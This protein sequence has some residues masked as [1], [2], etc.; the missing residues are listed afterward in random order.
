MLGAPRSI[1]KGRCK[2]GS[3]GA[4]CSRH[5]RQGHRRCCPVPPPCSQHVPAS[6]SRGGGSLCPS[7]PI[8]SHRVSPRVMGRSEPLQ[9]GGGGG[10]FAPPPALQ[11]GCT[12]VLN[13]AA[14]P[15][16]KTSRHT[17][18]LLRCR[19]SPARGSARSHQRSPCPARRSS[20]QL[21][22]R[23][24]ATLGG[25]PWSLKTCFSPSFNQ[26]HPGP[27]PAAVPTSSLRTATTRASAVGFLPGPPRGRREQ[28]LCSIAAR[29]CEPPGNAFGSGRDNAVG[30]H[31]DTGICQ[32]PVSADAG[33]FAGASGAESAQDRWRRELFIHTEAVW[34]PPI[35]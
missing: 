3:A 22:S 10:P 13:W 34:L 8:P 23:R 18:S 4:P 12:A 25:V 5:K 11:R 17:A 26:A 16:P 28:L 24:H 9:P 6:R 32:G 19:T 15:G 2:A 29:T 27:S 35:W 21:P 33:C 31:T 7:I 1:S 20:A 30:F 14:R